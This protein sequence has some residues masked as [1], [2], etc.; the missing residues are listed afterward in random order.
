[1][2]REMFRKIYEN[3]ELYDFD[4]KYCNEIFRAKKL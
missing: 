4:E 1:M 3:F 2:D